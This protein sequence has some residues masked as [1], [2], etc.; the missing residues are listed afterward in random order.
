MKN[1]FVA[2]IALVL[3]VVTYNSFAQTPIIPIPTS[4]PVFNQTVPSNQDLPD[5]QRPPLV[6]A[7]VKGSVYI[8]KGDEK[9]QFRVTVF[10]LVNNRW[11]NVNNFSTL[12]KPNGEYLTVIRGEGTYRFV[13]TVKFDPKFKYTFRPANHTVRIREGANNAIF[14]RNFNYKKDNRK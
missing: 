4:R 5:K 10:K 2:L 7:T 6:S 13:P 9:A 11:V 14:I 8:K 1:Y 12:V 3:S